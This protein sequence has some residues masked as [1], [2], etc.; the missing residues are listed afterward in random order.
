[1]RRSSDLR[2]WVNKLLEYKLG[3]VDLKL[4][5]PWQLLVVGCS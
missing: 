3:C 2:M 4:A 5:T 1:V